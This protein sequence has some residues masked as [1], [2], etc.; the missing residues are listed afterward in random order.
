MVLIA[1][2]RHDVLVIGFIL[3]ALLVLSGPLAV[4]AGVDSRVDDVARG[5]LGR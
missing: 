2:T 5:R 3:I 1:S 4:F